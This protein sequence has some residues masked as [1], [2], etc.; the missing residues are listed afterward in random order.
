MYT[1]SHIFLHSK[2]HMWQCVF[3]F[4]IVWAFHDIGNKMSLVILLCTCVAIFV[5]SRHYALKYLLFHLVVKMFPELKLWNTKLHSSEGNILNAKEIIR[6]SL[7]QVNIW[8]T[9]MRHVIMDIII[10]I[11]AITCSDVT[12]K[13]TCFRLTTLFFSAWRKFSYFLSCN[14][15]LV[16][17]TNFADFQRRA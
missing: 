12:N 8:I 6:A 11:L 3:R 1:Y 5:G 9:C 14:V 7:L 17:S 13:I 4:L 2:V 10:Y 15:N 16:N